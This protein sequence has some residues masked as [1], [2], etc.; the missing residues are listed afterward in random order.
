MRKTKILI[1][2]DNPIV[3]EDIRI[4]LEQMDYEV[5]AIASSGREAIEA[6]GKYC[7]DISLM[8]IR[9]GDGMNG[10]DAASELKRLHKISVIYL[11]AFADEDTIERA[12]KTEPYGYIV[13]P[14][15][16]SDLKSNI[17]IALYK[18][19]SDR[20]V[21]ESQQ[22]F[23]TT[24]S[25]I[26]DGVIATDMDG[27]ISFINPVAE[28]L[29]G[30]SKEEACGKPLHKVFKIIN[31]ISRK[32]CEN[33]VSKVIETGQII[34]LANHT[35]L[36]SRDG[37]EIP[38][39]DSG[40]P[41]QLNGI[42]NLGVVLIFQDDTK[43]RQSQEAIRKQNH[44]F[45]A[46]NRLFSGAIK[47]HT[48][49]EVAQLCLS[50]AEEVTGCQYGSIA[51]VNDKKRFDTLALS[52]TGWEQC[53]MAELD[54][55]CIQDM[56][57]RGIWK[58]ALNS[59]NGM[60]INDPS[61]HPMSVGVPKDHPPLNS[62][63]GV[64]FSHAN[65]N[66]MIGIANKQGGFTDM[67]REIIMA[68][69]LAFAEVI[70]NQRSEE[71]LL[72]SEERF[73]SLFE[74]SPLGYQSLDA[75]GDFL[76][77][78]E[79]WCKLLGYTKEEVLGRN[80]SEF[81]HP[82]FKEVFKENFP[83]FKKI[84]YI[85]GIEFEMIKKDGSE[86]IVA[87]DGK[88]GH[89]DDGSFKQTHCVLSDITKR[90]KSEDK[91]RSVFQLNQ[92]IINSSPMGMSIYNSDGNCI[93]VNT[94]AAKT[95]GATQAQLLEQNYHQID[96]WKES[97]LYDAALISL[98]E[99]VK[100]R[101]EINVKTTFG[102][103]CTLD[104]HLVPIIIDNEP[105]LLTMFEDISE[106]K[107]SEK[108]S[109]RFGR[110]FEDSLN[111]IYL[112]D[113]DTLRFTQVNKAAQLN[114]GYTL[115][116]LNKLTPLDL[117]PEFTAKSFEEILEPLREGKIE[118]TVFET[119]HRRKDESI[120]DVEVHLQLLRYEHETIFAAIIL[121]I[122]EKRKLQA[123]LMQG[124][125][126]ESIGNLAGG[127]AHDFNNILSS[128]IGFTEL[129]LDETQK[130]TTQEDNLQEVYTAG[131]RAKDLVA[132]IL[133]FARQS[134]A[135][136]KPIQVEII[137]KEVL[138]FIRS[139]IPTN[140]EIKQNI[141]SDSL[142]MG[143]QTQVDQIMMNLC[144]NAAYAMED[145]GGVLKV[146]LKDIKVDRTIG[147]K[148]NLTP[149]NYIELT[150]SDT[151]VGIPPDNINLI[152]EPYFTTKEVGEGTGMGL[153]MI[154]GII[155]SYGGKIT[156]NSTLGEGA[157]FTV[158][159]PLTRKQKTKHQYQP[160]KLPEG[161]ERILFVDDE[162][163]IAKMGARGLK[164]LGYQVTTRTSSVEALELFRSKPNEFDLVIT[165]MTMPNMTGDSLAI[166]LME[167]RSDIPI[168]LCTGYS[169]KISDED[170]SGIGIKA[171]AYKPIVKADLAKTVR[172][173]LDE[174]KG[175]KT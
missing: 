83:K 127:I 90:K 78:N 77:L 52:N 92:I 163:P 38:I 161:T 10:I 119:V 87:I 124:Q 82:D 41:I 27:C 35:L 99:K 9:L 33:P 2:E 8:D 120:Y 70:N 72:E 53:R 128:I 48:S 94:T 59:E 131:K 28:S 12:K 137:I 110:I 7:P 85:L 152:F 29:T 138:N 30:W 15:R 96:S 55:S 13:K 75:N 88:I 111:E 43:N 18:Q 63:L 68:L 91:L 1:V 22:W 36:V 125:K 160:T 150:V 143:N 24:L 115:V 132:Q 79:S 154:H 109:V 151:G 25:S 97:G 134:E 129:A 4:K 142:I 11:T 34:G 148:I 67:D 104:I 147:K 140:I 175:S 167:I 121:D 108:R 149:G 37:R 54:P 3:A 74:N 173:V 73:R 133:A 80:F 116:E 139:T 126:L 118:R 5:V 169:K 6:A 16:N 100:K 44:V 174:A 168:I 166:E 146:S 23:E 117:K 144:T 51:E 122:T 123:Q 71:A 145:D 76:E 50:I 64:P 84:G 86:I 14:F 40:A 114:T 56:E 159:M 60:I 19:R 39:K 81:I 32:P 103:N 157:T 165:D 95:V 102:R 113:A 106:R 26:G 45:K 105:H 130:D 155:E 61:S 42:E 69:A 164:S 171:F 57:I 65:F 112:F 49:T 101:H 93:A 153:A 170:A 135:D 47:C 141:E 20:L 89:K 98:Q 31:E 107:Q 17:E 58:A 158:Y 62:F 46:I 66:G 162:V 136:L 156:V 21:R 172:K